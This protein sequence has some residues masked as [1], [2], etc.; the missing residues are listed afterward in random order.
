M[1]ARSRISHPAS[2][3]TS[4]KRLQPRRARASNLLLTER[5][6]RAPIRAAAAYRLQARR[7]Q[8]TISLFCLIAFPRSPLRP[9]LAYARDRGRAGAGAGKGDDE[10]LVVLVLVL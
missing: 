9:R 3:A 7:G 10:V 8:R 2:D 5:C 6:S 1:L 4:L